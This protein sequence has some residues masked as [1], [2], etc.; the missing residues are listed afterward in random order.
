MGKSGDLIRDFVAHQ[1]SLPGSIT[2]AELSRRVGVSRPTL[3]RYLAGP[4]PG[5]D[6]ID[7]IA[8]AFRIQAWELIKPEG[9]MPTQA[10]I[11]PEVLSA[12]S[13]LGE[14]AK[15]FMDQIQARSPKA[16]GSDR[17]ADLADPRREIAAILPTLDEDQ[18]RL[19]LKFVRGLTGRST[20]ESSTKAPKKIKGDS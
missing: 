2:K 15:K 1:L 18:A 9:A 13:M 10:V 3:D 19:A 5:A 14:Q 6:E 12:L 11:A 7:K 20:S 17:D 4:F 16:A 8:E